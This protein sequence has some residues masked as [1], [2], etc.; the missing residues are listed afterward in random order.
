MRNEGDLEPLRFGDLYVSPASESAQ[1]AALLPIEGSEDMSSLL[2]IIPVSG[3]TSSDREEYLPCPASEWIVRASFAT[4]LEVP[5]VAKLFGKDWTA[6]HGV[7]TIY[8]KN[9]ATG[10]W[11][12]LISADG[13]KHVSSL[14]FAWPYYPTW[15]PEAGVVS[16]AVYQARLREVER[17]LC[18]LANVSV[19]T[20]VAPES[21][22]D[23]S[24]LL[25]ELSARF[26]R[27][28]TVRLA[29][30]SGTLFPGKA[31][32]DV[33]LCLGL[34]WGDMDCFHWPNPSEYGDDFFFG[35]WTSTAPGYFL[36]EEVANDRVNVSDLI[37]GYSLPRS[38]DPVAVFERMIRAVKYAQRR[39]GGVITTEDGHAFDLTGT[40]REIQTLVIQLDEL[41]FRPGSEAALRQF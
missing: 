31:I 6:G 38:A 41:G 2:E 32:W 28:V 13:P 15:S 7:A 5:D 40:A 3:L 36:P 29:A 12:F 19:H 8:G 33:M 11:T 10:L 30:P 16:P 1:R 27:S 24:K 37:F 9:T 17:R 34:Q 23:R 14:Q 20:D 21:A 25:S 35:V 39:L 26:G 22:H 4:P 18:Q